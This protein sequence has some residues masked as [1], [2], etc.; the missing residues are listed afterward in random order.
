MCK[1][2]KGG[3]D[4]IFGIPIDNVIFARVFQSFI[5]SS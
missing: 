4:S 3:D 2:S 1:V 5:D